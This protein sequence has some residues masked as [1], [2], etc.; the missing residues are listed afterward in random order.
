VCGRHCEL[1]TLPSLQRSHAARQ[2]SVTVGNTPRQFPTWPSRSAAARCE[3]VGP[4]P[5]PVAPCSTYIPRRQDTHSFSNGAEEEEEEAAA[6]GVPA[7][8]KPPRARLPPTPL[9]LPRSAGSCPCASSDPAVKPSRLRS[10]RKL[11]VV[12][13]WAYFAAPA[14]TV[15]PSGVLGTSLPRHWLLASP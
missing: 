4:V 13:R 15:L 14:G 6:G 2:T 5:S 11:P 9:P 10:A 12:P 8:E 3:R 1:H 7:P